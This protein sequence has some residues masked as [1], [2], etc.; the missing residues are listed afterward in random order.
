V[1][2]SLLL[3]MIC[4]LGACEPEPELAVAE[5]SLLDNVAPYNAVPRDPPRALEEPSEA[6]LR[7]RAKVAE[8]TPDNAVEK[9][10]E[11]EK[12]LQDQIANLET[13]LAPVELDMAE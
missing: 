1:K 6:Q 2:K 11:L 10:K 9:A 3:V 5:A 7:L 12:E 13:R 8:I 4:A